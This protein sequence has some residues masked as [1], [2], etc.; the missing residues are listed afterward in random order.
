MNLLTASVL[1]CGVFAAGLV[2][3]LS[4][5]D[6]RERLPDCQTRDPNRTTLIT[7]TWSADRQAY[8]CTCRTVTSRGKQ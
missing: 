5:L 4:G 3:A 1:S 2:L 8:D 6:T 7:C